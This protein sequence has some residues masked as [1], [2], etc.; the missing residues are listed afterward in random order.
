MRLPYSLARLPRRIAEL[1]PALILLTVLGASLALASWAVRFWDDLPAYAI[2]NTL[3]PDAR[4]ELLKRMALGGVLAMLGGLGIGFVGGHFEGFRV[5]RFAARVGPLC[6]A[7]PVPFLFH[8]ELWKGHDLTFL[9]MLALLGVALQGLLRQAL[10]SKPVLAG[11]RWLPSVDSEAQWWP[12]NPPLQRSWLPFLVVVGGTIAYAIYFSKITIDAHYRLETAAMDLGVWNNLHW[13]AV[14]GG[15]LFKTSPLGGPTSTHSGHHQT[16]FAYVIAL[17]Y[18]FAQGPETLL[19]VQSVLLGAGAIP[20]YLLARHRVGPWTGVAL[21]AAY[22]LYPALHGPNLYEFHFLALAPFF[23]MMTL[24]CVDTRRTA[25]AVVFGLLTLS[26]REDVSAL[27]AVLGLFVLLERRHP[28]AGVVMML[29]GSACFVAL[30]LIVMPRYT[31]GASTFLDTFEGLLPAGETSFTGVIKTIVGNPVFAF[32]SVLTHDKLVYLLQILGPLALLVWRRP[33]GF[34]LSIPGFLFTILSTGY[35]PLIEIYFQYASYW[36]GFMFI[37]VVANLGWMRQQEREHRLPAAARWAWV[38]AVLV[39]SVIGSHQYGAVLQGENM[40][41]GF[42]RFTYG[43]SHED[44]ERHRRLYELIAMVPADAKI[45][46]SERIVPHVS[47]R[48]D[49]YT[50]RTGIYD[51][52]YLLLWMPPSG[53]ERHHFEA[54]FRHGTF[55]VI[56]KRGEFVLAK[57]GADPSNNAASIGVVR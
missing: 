35:K 14:H 8:W 43:I 7:A 33:L 17:V 31:G 57:R 39:T 18:Y 22:L 12:Q 40:R 6:L 53:L 10:D 29:A 24:Y 50:L 44:H 3:E 54:A 34:V 2:S 36:T 30:K 32:N 42:R 13:N 56:A 11:V 48:R 5:Q 21:A 45:C 27:F 25:M 47:N 38:V 37:A 20:L 16:Y 23:L 4:A 49:S 41:G 9:A 15:A 26:L 55:G 51:A 28:L 46:S 19:V 1:V 52:E